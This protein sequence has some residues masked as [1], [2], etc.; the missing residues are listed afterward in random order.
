MIIGLLWYWLEVKSRYGL[1]IIY[2]KTAPNCRF[3]QS[4]KRKY[5]LS[6]MRLRSVFKMRTSILNTATTEQMG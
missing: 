4:E 5:P 2:Q 6:Q 3:A 1:S